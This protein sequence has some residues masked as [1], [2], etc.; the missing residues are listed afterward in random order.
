MALGLA[1]LVWEMPGDFGSEPREKK[2]FDSVQC[3]RVHPSN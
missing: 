2:H 3:H 1:L